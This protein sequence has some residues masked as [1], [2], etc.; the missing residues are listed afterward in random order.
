MKILLDTELADHRAHALKKKLILQVSIFGE[1]G[2][3]LRSQNKLICQWT[4]GLQAHIFTYPDSPL[5][6]NRENLKISWVP[7]C[8]C[9]MQVVAW[10]LPVFHR[11]KIFCLWAEIKASTSNEQ[12]PPFIRVHFPNL[13]Q[14]TTSAELLWKPLCCMLWRCAKVQDQPGRWQQPVPMG[15]WSDKWVWHL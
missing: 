15:E 10:A 6:A 8:L 2:N 4:C 5:F 7:E 13:T 14:I 11:H 1:E 12:H 3:I 9:E